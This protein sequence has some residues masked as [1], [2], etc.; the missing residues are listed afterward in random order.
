MKKL[1]SLLL[2]V[3]FM[4]VMVFGL[5][6]CETEEAVET[7][8]EEVVDEEQA[9]EE[10]VEEPEEETDEPEEALD[11]GAVLLEA[12]KDYF[13][14]TATDNN[15]MPPAD[16]KEMLDSNPNSIFIL[17]IRSAEDFEAGHIP[18]AV[19]SAWAEVGNIMDRIPQNKP[20]VVTCYSGQTA[21][22]TVA[23]LRMAGFDNVKSL[24]SGISL[25]WVEAAGLPLDETGMN[26]AGDLD[27]VSSPAAEKEEIIWEAAKEF[28]AAVA[29]DNNIIPGPELNDA[30]E[31]NP[32]SFYVLDIR[33]ADD[34]AAGHIAGSVHSPWS[35]VSNLL[36]DLPSTRPIAVGCYSGQTAGQTVG[37]LRLLGFDAYS[38]QFGIRDGW[39][40]KEGL[41][42]VTE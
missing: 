15:I 9:D 7:P 31:A 18:G 42:V 32:N 40:E 35:E 3:L 23:V 37:V 36:E 24:Q 2:V 28:F 29:S 13:A 39:V 10:A 4:G 22:Q 20:V 16:V 5:V 12:A 38:V 8:E 27:S 33:S 25:G 1:F 26:A 17:D 14:K 30:L 19:H 6:G 41:P 34:Y 21:G 11:A